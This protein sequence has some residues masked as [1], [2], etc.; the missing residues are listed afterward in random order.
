MNVEGPAVEVRLNSRSSEMK[1]GGSK[2]GIT[3]VEESP[4][5]SLDSGGK[6]LPGSIA[7]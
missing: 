3:A 6:V 5:T 7:P 1:N 2:S 4:R